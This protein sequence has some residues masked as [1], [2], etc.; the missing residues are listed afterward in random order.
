MRKFFAISLALGAGGLLFA[1]SQS[2]GSFAP[3]DSPALAGASTNGE[4]LIFSDKGFDAYYKLKTIIYHDNVRVFNPQMKLTC[5][6]LTVE[7]PELPEGKFNRVTAETNVV[8]D[9]VDDNGTN[10]ATADKAVYTYTLTNLA[11]LPELRWETNSL[12]VLSGHPYV[13]NK[14]GTW[15]GDPIIWDRI[16]AVIS[17]PSLSKSSI[18]PTNSSKMFGTEPPKTNSTPK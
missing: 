1:Q 5:E 7:S 11:K 14:I 4:T 6:L 10:H 15:N 2:T 9:W 16:R 3:G 8:I 18:N 13:T 12:V 17:T